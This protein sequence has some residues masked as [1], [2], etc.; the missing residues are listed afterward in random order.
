MSKILKHRWGFGLGAA[1]SAAAVIIA[2][3]V[4]TSPKAFGL[5]QVIEAYNHV[6]FLHV[7][8]YPGDS[9][10]AERILDQGR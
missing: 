10:N 3:I 9:K 5:E 6:R 1:A 4:T 8:T 2:I 7:K